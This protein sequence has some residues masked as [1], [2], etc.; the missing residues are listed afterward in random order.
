LLSLRFL[1]PVFAFLFQ[2]L[3]VGSGLLLLFTLP[4]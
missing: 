2:S 3:R 4:S 1:F